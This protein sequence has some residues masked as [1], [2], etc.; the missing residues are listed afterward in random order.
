MS[1]DTEIRFD[2][3]D[4]KTTEAAYEKASEFGNWGMQKV[5]DTVYVNLD[6][7]TPEERK[8]ICKTLSAFSDD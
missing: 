8:S 5:S 6:R 3:S 2:F 4:G 7:Y 1:N